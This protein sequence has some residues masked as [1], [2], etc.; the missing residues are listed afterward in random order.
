MK[1][2]TKADSVPSAETDAD[3][4]NQLMLIPSA[5]IEQNPMLNAVPGNK[6]DNYVRKNIIKRN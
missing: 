6:K 5:K 2:L 3:S 1:E 4:S